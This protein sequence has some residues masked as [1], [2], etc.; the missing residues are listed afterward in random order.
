MKD[1]VSAGRFVSSVTLMR[2]KHKPSA[3]V[4]VNRNVR[5]HGLIPSFPF[6][7]NTSRFL[8]KNKVSGGASA[9]Q[10]LL[11]G[12]RKLWCIAKCFGDLGEGGW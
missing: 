8:K 5:G 1:T 3:S 2:S 9:G 7:I 4:H 12:G 10:A 11:R 6:P